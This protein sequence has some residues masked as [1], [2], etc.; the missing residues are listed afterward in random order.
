MSVL[1]G[2][3]APPQNHHREAPIKAHGI[4]GWQS[5]NWGNSVEAGGAWRPS[6]LERQVARERQEIKRAISLSAPGW[7]PNQLNKI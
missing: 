2:S 1:G 7:G 6:G 5:W 4:S 3:Q